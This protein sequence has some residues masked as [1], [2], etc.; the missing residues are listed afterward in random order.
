MFSVFQLRHFIFNKHVL[1][2]NKII[3]LCNAPL[4]L[5]DVIRLRV[6]SMGLKIR[7]DLIRRFSRGMLYFNVPRFLYVS[8]KLMF[9]LVFDEP[10]K[11]DLAYPQKFID[12]YRGADIY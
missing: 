8:Y 10:R 2:N 4:Q 12:V 6:K 1:I 9:G 3:T 7:F 5:G 11:I